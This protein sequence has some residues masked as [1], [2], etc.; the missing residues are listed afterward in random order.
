[1]NRNTDIRILFFIGVGVMVLL[2]TG[3]LLALIFNQRKKLKHQQDMQGLKEQQQNQLI[4][5]AV[6]SE[7]SERHR[8]A[9]TLHD[10]VGGLLS[11]AKL[12]LLGIDEESLTEK[13][14]KLH[15]KGR[16][17]LTDVIHKVRGISHNLHSHILKEF[18]LN[19]AIRHFLT[20][21]T[22]GTT[23]QAETALDENYVTTN[24]DRDISLYR[25]VQELINNILKHAK[26]G[27]IRIESRLHTN[28]LQII[29]HHNGE[30]LT[31]EAYEAH[32]FQKEGLGL[33]NIRNRV[34]LLR[35]TL[36]FSKNSSEYTVQITVP[37]KPAGYA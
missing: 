3:V 25:M 13:D 10:E 33:K 36:Q 16:H 34:L 11:S 17:L 18:G 20:Q 37:E 24:Q 2:F 23:I 22:G 12:H 15:D 28:E 4:E 7:E 30:G 26:A 5:A 9:E 1:M 6:K 35:G 32:S 21:V 29:I 27:R 31:Q 8:I 14:R 19:E